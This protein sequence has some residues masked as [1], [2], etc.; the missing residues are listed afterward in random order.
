MLPPS[1][2]SRRFGN[3]KS[4]NTEIT[5]RK[6]EERERERAGEYQAIDYEREES[7]SYYSR[8]PLCEM[9]QSETPHRSAVDAIT[10]KQIL[11]RIQ[12]DGYKYTREKFE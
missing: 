10:D 12:I 3:R 9:L 4:R 11:E 8:Q 7:H 1:A 5:Q 2:E 6:R